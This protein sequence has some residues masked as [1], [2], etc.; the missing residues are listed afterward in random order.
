MAGTD[1]TSWLEGME[2]DEEGAFPDS[3]QGWSDKT[4]IDGLEDKTQLMSEADSGK[5]QLALAGLGG[6]EG[7]GVSDPVTGWLVVIQGPGLGN[8]VQIG[9][10]MNVIGRSEEER[11]A[12]PFGDMQ[13]SSKDHV[14]IIYDDEGRNFMIVPGSGKNVSRLNGQIVAM[15]MLLPSASVIQLS[16]NTR[17]RFVA[18]CSQEFDWSDLADDAK[19]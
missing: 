7:A 3:I 11:V 12:L 19:G 13:I 9:S 6:A 4:S 16:K 18:F 15:P 14:R 10:G 5:T 17:V 8:S 2:H 1:K